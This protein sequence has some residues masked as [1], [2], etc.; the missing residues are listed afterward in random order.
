M[1]SKKGTVVKMNKKKLVG[2]VCAFACAAN[3]ALSE[4]ASADLR[5]LADQEWWANQLVV[6]MFGNGGP[7]APSVAGKT[8]ELE[9]HRIQ[10]KICD[11]NGIVMTSMRFQSFDDYKTKVHP[12]TVVGGYYLRGI[13]VGCGDI[14]LG[15]D[16]FNDAKGLKNQYEY[17]LCDRIV[18]HELTHAVEGHTLSPSWEGAKGETRAEFGSVELSDKLP[19]GGWGVYGVALRYSN[20]YAEYAKEVMKSFEKECRGKVSITPNGSLVTYHDQN[21]GN[22]NLAVIDEVSPD[23]AYFGGQVANCIAKGAFR[24]DN[25]RIMDNFLKQDIKFNGDYLL[26]CK[27][28]R[29]P[30]GYRILTELYGTKTDLISQLEDT[31]RSVRTDKP[32]N[33]YVV[34]ASELVR[35]GNS[36]PWKLWL[37]CAVAA[38]MD[39]RR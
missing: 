36:T 29:L 3:L 16:Y 19:E 18:S 38:D 1:C 34:T 26:V 37:A 27:D 30:N 10:K 13:A 5:T 21:G 35:P 39:G 20:G 6:K 22:Y 12:I 17:M 7:E 8:L 15:E 9:V 11:A 24:L 4:T 28:S 23:N 32:L 25:I 31:K 33:T 14:Y 2:A